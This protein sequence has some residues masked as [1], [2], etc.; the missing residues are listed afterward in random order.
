MLENEIGTLC[1]A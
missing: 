1:S